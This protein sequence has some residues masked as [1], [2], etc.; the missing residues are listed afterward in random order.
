MTPATPAPPTAPTLT[1]SEAVDACRVSR[2]TLQRRKSEL[3]ALGAQITP[4]GWAIPIPALVQLGLLDRTTP[5]ET[6]A[7]AAP[8]PSPTPASE[9]STDT[10]VLLTDEVARLRAELAEAKQRAAVAEAVAAE[11][12]ASL[13]RAD[14]TLLVLE[15][16]KPEPIRTP[17]PAAAAP[18]RQRTLLDRVRRVLTQ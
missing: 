10:R 2:S 18:R 1:L 11:R 9:P 3:I 12:K 6:A 5:A 17:I 4:T 15:A 13:E 14:R 7:P 16:G 8:A